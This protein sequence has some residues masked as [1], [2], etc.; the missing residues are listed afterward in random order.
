MQKMQ[1]LNTTHRSNMTPEQRSKYIELM[2]QREYEGMDYKDIEG[3]LIAYFITD[4]SKLDDADILLELKELFPDLL[5]QYP[6][7]AK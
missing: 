7:E 3:L 5:E 1:A 2:A 4:L 6:L